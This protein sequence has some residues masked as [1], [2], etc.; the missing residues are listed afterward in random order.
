MNNNQAASAGWSKSKVQEGRGGGDF[1]EQVRELEAALSLLSHHTLE[2][3]KAAAVLHDEERARLKL[4]KKW[5][6]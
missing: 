4:W 5:T 1:G 3:V 6:V 2:V